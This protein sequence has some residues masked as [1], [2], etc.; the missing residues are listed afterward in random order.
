MRNISIE[1]IKMLWWRNY[2]ESDWIRT[3]LLRSRPADK[4]QTTARMTPTAKIRSSLP[5]TRCSAEH[6]P[7]DLLSL[8]KNVKDEFKDNLSE[9]IVI[10]RLRCYSIHRSVQNNFHWETDRHRPSKIPLFLKLQWKEEHCCCLSMGISTLWSFIDFSQPTLKI[11][12]KSTVKKSFL[13]E[14]LPMYSLHL[15]KYNINRSQCFERVLITLHYAKRI[16][17]MQKKM[18]YDGQYTM[19]LSLSQSRGKTL[20]SGCVSLTEFVWFPWWNW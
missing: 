12:S 19:P 7:R 13:M 18:F 11:K 5:L 1:N 4:V 2:A 9:V 6:A 16:S 17:V 10:W 15:Q 3:P 14:A 8:P 20:L